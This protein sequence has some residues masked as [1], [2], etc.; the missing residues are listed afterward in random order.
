MSVANINANSTALVQVI[1]S[2]ENRQRV[3]N[4]NGSLQTISVKKKD[5]KNKLR[6]THNKSVATSSEEVQY[7]EA[8]DTLR[9]AEARS[10]LRHF[11]ADAYA[12][13]QD[14]EQRTALKY[15]FYFS[16]YA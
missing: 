6:A 14:Y 11:G 7:K 10:R 9:E 13:V 8:Y 2:N 4:Q 12:Q 5:K 3:Q 1:Q 15:K 16:A